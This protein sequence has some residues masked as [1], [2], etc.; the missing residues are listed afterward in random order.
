MVTGEELVQKTKATYDNPLVEMKATYDAISR[1][2]TTLEERQKK[3]LFH[4]NRINTNIESV[5]NAAKNI[6]SP[7][8]LRIFKE[9]YPVIIDT[10]KKINELISEIM[11][12][13]APNITGKIEKVAKLIDDNEE[14]IANIKEFKREVEEHYH[15]VESAK[16]FCE[17]AEKFLN[18]SDAKIAPLR[19]KAREIG[20]RD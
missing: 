4:S 19:S 15:K 1:E 7:V 8:S 6:S 18:D 10:K 11:H 2:I 14:R 17:E 5:S 16:I 12:S 9:T 3:I 13:V 20:I